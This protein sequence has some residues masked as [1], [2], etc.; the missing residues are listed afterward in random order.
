[1]SSFRDVARALG[2]ALWILV[3]ALLV[4]GTLMWLHGY[5]IG[6]APYDEW[7]VNLIAG[8]MVAA[9]GLI[10]LACGAMLRRR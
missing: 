8:P 4:I 5:F 3:W 9:L 6:P 10:V 1:M 7:E 2:K